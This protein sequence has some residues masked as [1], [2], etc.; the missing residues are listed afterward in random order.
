MTVEAILEAA[1]HV[2]AEHGYAAGTTNRIAERAGVSIGSLYQYC[3]HKNTVLVALV[4]RHIEEGLAR[5]EGLLAEVAQTPEDLATLLRRFVAEMVDLHSRE[6]ELHRALFEEA[7]HPPELHECV[8]ALEERLAHTLEAL[9]RSC[10]EVSAGDL[11]TAAHL[12]VQVVEALTHRFA[13]HGIH[14]LETEDF[15][16]EVVQLLLGYL[17]GAGAS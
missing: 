13:L 14:D 16:D 10:P 17:A 8:L 3:P 12:L 5:V 1:A 9:L 15:V 6:P 2:F 4:E 7:P 11:D